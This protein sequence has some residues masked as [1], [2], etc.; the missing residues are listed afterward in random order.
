MDTW[1]KSLLSGSAHKGIR[2]GVDSLHLVVHNSLVGQWIRLIL[3]LEMP[4]F[5]LKNERIGN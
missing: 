1:E 2:R 3:K 4:T 5:L